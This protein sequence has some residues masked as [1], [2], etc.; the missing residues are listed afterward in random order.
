[1]KHNITSCLRNLFFLV[2]MHYLSFVTLK[3][4]ERLSSNSNSAENCR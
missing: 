3:D 2:L 4:R 1:M